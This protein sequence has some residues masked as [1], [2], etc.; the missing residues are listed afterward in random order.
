MAIW[1]MKAG[2]SVAPARFV[3]QVTTADHQVAQCGAGD[4]VFGV[5]QAGTRRAP[6]S[7]LDDGYAAITG[8]DIEVF[9]VGEKPMLELG[10]TVAAGDRLKA[11]SSGR[12]VV[13]V[14]NLD[15]WGAVALVAGT[16]GKLV[17][18]EVQPRG[19]VSS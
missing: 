11:D 19:Q 17:P 18:V 6:Y 2:G 7:T 10:G 14:T 5:S 4:K 13:T 15:E 3:K 9:G 12:G 1:S 16:V 8:E